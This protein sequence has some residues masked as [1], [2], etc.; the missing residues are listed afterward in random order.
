MDFAGWRV[1]LTEAELDTAERG[2]SPLCFSIEPME[3]RKPRENVPG[4]RE[5]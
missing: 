3:P 1:S 4:E 5:N 2:S